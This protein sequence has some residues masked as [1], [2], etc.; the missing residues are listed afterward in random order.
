[1][2]CSVAVPVDPPVLAALVLCALLAGFVD[3]IAGGGGLIQL[4]PLLAFVG[5]AYAPGTNKVASLCGTSAALVR[6][7]R[8]GSVRWDRVALVGPIAFAGSL[9]GTL[10]YLELVRRHARDVEPAF[11]VAFLLLAADQVRRTLRP[12]PAPTT[13]PRPRVAW[14]LAAAAAIALY[15]GAIGPGTGIFLFWAFTTWFA[16]PPLHATGT[17]KAVNA[18]TNAGSL[19]A[20]I[21]DGKVLWPVALAMAAANVVGGLLGARTA[22]RHGVRVIRLVTAVA[23]AGAAVYLLVRWATA[24]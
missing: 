14:G 6:Y 7:A 20:F 15:D 1:M 10:G 5:P 11:A 19:T 22:I 12:P 21:A 18:L 24:R 9:A 3:A 16:L 2:A 8:H 13:P 17:T 23:C 4:P